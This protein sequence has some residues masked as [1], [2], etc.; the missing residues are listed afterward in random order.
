VCFLEA[1]DREVDADRLV[2]LRRMMELERELVPER[3][4]ESISEPLRRPCTVRA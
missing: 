4:S 1:T 2:R 3:A